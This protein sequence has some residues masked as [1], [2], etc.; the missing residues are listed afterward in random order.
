MLHWILTGAAF[1]GA[2][3]LAILANHKSGQTWDEP[4]PRLI[5]W[6]LVMIVAVFLALMAI[7]HAFNLMGLETG[8][9]NSPF[10]RF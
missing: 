5:P 9:E 1:A 7:V 10:G 3:A 6:R 2:V 4:R 8:R